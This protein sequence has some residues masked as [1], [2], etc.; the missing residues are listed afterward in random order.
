MIK[1]NIQE[2][3]FK[4]RS[5]DIKEIALVM[6]YKNMCQAVYQL[7]VNKVNYGFKNINWLN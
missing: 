7:K 6:L 3:N 2:F 5:N 1:K 4:I